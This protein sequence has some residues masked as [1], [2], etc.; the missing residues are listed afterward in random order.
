MGMM[1]RARAAVRALFTAPGADAGQ[2]GAI[3]GAADGLNDP[4]GATV[5]NLLGGRGGRGVP[6]SEAAAMSLPAVLRALEVLCSLFAMAPLIYYRSDGTGKTRV[7]DVP[8]AVMLRRRP[9]EVQK[10]MPIAGGRRRY[11]RSGQARR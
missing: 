1:I 2:S 4:T 3:V 6:V 5:L 11:H 10:P 8:N 9:N 7:D